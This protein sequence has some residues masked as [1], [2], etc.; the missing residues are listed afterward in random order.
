MVE[1]S[2]NEVPL[3]ALQL[4]RVNSMSQP[5]SQQTTVKGAS[6]FNSEC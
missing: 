1:K 6:I 5:T 3:A 4:L 2:Y